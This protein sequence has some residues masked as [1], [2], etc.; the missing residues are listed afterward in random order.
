[1]QDIDSLLDIALEIEGL[2]RVLMIRDDSQV[3]ALLQKKAQSL[4]DSLGQKPDSAISC[5]PV[6]TQPACGQ[7][8]TED[9]TQAKDEEC[10][11]PIDLDSTFSVDILE[12]DDEA[13]TAKHAE[14]APEKEHSPE[15]AIE[16]AAEADKGAAQPQEEIAVQNSESAAEPEPA[17]RPAKSFIT[18]NEKYRFVR[19]LFNNQHALMSEVV[20]K[21][22]S[23]NSLPEAHDYVLNELNLDEDNPVVIEF[24]EVIA[25]YFNNRS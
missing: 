14:P 8:A 21:V 15:P 18:F 17:P 19:E 10:M 5:P 9:D 3:R 11:Q 4:A 7:V 6:E 23:M 13:A 20:A 22:T 2:V 16:P 12:F 24:L 25:R 1:M